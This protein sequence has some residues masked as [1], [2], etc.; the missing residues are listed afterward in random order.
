MDS[1]WQLLLRLLHL[2]LLLLQ[3]LLDFKLLHLPAETILL[4]GLLCLRQLV[5]FDFSGHG[6]RF[7]LLLDRL[8][9]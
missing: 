4:L 2:L 6:L 3:L 7:S 1:W 5:F 9:S 8:L